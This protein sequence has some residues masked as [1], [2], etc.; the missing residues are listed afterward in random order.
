MSADSVIIA[1]AALRKQ[2]RIAPKFGYQESMNIVTGLQFE[3]ILSESGPYGGQILRP[4][5]G[6]IPRS[7]GFILAVE[8][9]ASHITRLSTA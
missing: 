9:K 7:I 5:D 3:R 1:P 6:D 8:P 2:A 4:H